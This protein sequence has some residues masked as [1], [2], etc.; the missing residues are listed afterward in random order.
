MVTA[1]KIVLANNQLSVTFGAN[2]T[3]NIDLIQVV[4]IEQLNG[5]VSWLSA[6][7]PQEVVYQ[8]MFDVAF[9]PQ[10]DR[11]YR[12]EKIKFNSKEYSR[13]IGV[14]AFAKLSYALDGSFKVFRTQYAMNE[15][16][17]K[18]RVT[19]RVLLDDKVV[20]EVK[21]F[22]PGKLSPVL[23]IDLEECEDA[24]A[25]GHTRAATRLRTIERNGT[26]IRRRD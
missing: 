12:G 19:V 4:L 1:P 3:R 20:H 9:P 7:V 22:G 24:Y 25:G 26:S 8:P 21:D 17:F 15:D 13:G 11:N 6:R 10:M 14:H 5:P 2:T 23:L 18:G 16:A